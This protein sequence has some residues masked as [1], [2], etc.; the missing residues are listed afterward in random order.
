V[1]DCYRVVNSGAG[2]EQC[3]DRRDPSRNMY[4]GSYVN[5]GL[6]VDG[7]TDL[8]LTCEDLGVIRLKEK[9]RM[10][11]AKVNIAALNLD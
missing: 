2:G 5:L 4:G 10:S 9:I 11:N 1:K 7:L 6:V 8:L 3:G